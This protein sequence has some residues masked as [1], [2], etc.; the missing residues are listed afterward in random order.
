MKYGRHKYDDIHAEDV[1]WSFKVFCRCR[2]CTAERK[3]LAR[4]VIRPDE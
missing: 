4:R 2:R 3:Q 1:S